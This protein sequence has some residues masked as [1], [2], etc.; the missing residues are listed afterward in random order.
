MLTFDDWKKAIVH[1]EC[2]ADSA[3][4]PER[5]AIMEEIQGVLKAGK[6]VDMELIERRNKILIEGLRNKR[7]QGTAI[8]LEHESCSYLI[9]ARHVIEDKS[10]PEEGIKWCGADRDNAYNIIFRVPSLD[11]VLS[12]RGFPLRNLMN[13]N[14]VNAVTFSDPELDLAIISLNNPL[15]KPF[16]EELIRDGYSPIS[17]EDIADEPS[18]EGADICAIGFPMATSLLG[19]LDLP[20][21][22]LHWSSDSFSLPI[23]SYGK[24]AMLHEN[25][26]YLWGDISTYPGNSGGPIIESGK[27]VGIVSA[28][29]TIYIEE[30]TNTET[31]EFVPFTART[32]IPFTKI[33]KSKYIKNLL[34]EQI[35]RDKWIS[36]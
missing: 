23:T 21:A 12:D 7:Y 5:K 14:T 34:D 32:R 17:L 4:W 6:Y 31:E 16:A 20:S 29:P 33:V 11:L 28:Q 13:L 10:F 26:S 24:V 35:E 9:T 19:T 25:L 27:L 18:D 8:F 15:Y 2:A 36:R 30:M 1:L 3:S 22:V